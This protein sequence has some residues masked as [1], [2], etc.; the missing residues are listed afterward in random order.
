LKGFQKLIALN[1]AWQAYISCIL[2]GE[3]NQVDNAG[4]KKY[5]GNF[6]TS[7]ATGVLEE[8]TAGAKDSIFHER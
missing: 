4:S 8:S 3:Q 1:K 7:T 5:D 2:K 6:E